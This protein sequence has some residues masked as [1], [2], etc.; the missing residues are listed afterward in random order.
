[1]NFFT[2]VNFISHNWYV[3]VLFLG[4]IVMTICACFILKALMAKR[5]VFKRSF[6]ASGTKK[7]TYNLWN[8]V[9]VFLIGFSGVV[10]LLITG[11][12]LIGN[13]I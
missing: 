2:T 1:M 4:S 13:L 7:L 5:K 11:G 10:G 3:M 8:L 6:E 12:I 9:L